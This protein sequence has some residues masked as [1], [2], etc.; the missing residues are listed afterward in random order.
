MFL[1]AAPR[2][3]TINLARPHAR[4]PPSRTTLSN[5]ARYADASPGGAAGGGAAPPEGGA[6]LP[7]SAAFTAPCPPPALLRLTDRP[8][9]RSSAHRRSCCSPGCS[10]EE[11]GQWCSW[12]SAQST[13]RATYESL[14]SVVLLLSASA[15][16][17]APASPIWFLLRLQRGRLF[18]ATPERSARQQGIAVAFAVGW[19]LCGITCGLIY[20]FIERDYARARRPTSRARSPRY[21]LRPRRSSHRPAAPGRPNRCGGLADPL[22]APAALRTSAAGT[23]HEPATLASLVQRENAEGS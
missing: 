11:E 2:P 6:P 1:L 5:A 17:L 7:P 20:F 23:R 15:R 22:A 3:T 10:E 21:R 12:R 14:V 8:R 18:K 4:L 16:D 19:P 9:S 13:A